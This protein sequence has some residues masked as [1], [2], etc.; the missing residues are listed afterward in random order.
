[1]H[2]VG[3]HRRGGR[4]A[5]GTGHAQSLVGLGE[6]AEHLGALLYLEAVLPEVLEFLVGIGDGR[7]IDDEARLLLLA[8]VGNLVDVLLVV[9]EHTLL[10]QTACQVGGRLV[11][12]AHDK[13]LVDEIAGDG[14]H[15]D[16]TGA[17]E[18]D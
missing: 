13:S 6:G 1:M 16:A 2:D 7:G 8:G 9:D 5:V 11:I 14:T 12:A 3:T 17:D 10:L 15:A 4:L 18:I